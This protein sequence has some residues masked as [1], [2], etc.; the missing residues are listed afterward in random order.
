VLVQRLLERLASLGYGHVETK[1][2]TAEDVT[3]SL[4]PWLR[5][6]AMEGDPARQEHAV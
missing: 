3:F 6:A 5:P 2:I 1:E 4:P